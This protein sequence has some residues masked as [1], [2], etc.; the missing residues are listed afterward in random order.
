MFSEPLS[1]SSS[2][3]ISHGRAMKIDAKLRV[4]GRFS[5][6]AQSL[7]QLRLSTYQETHKGAAYVCFLSSLEQNFGNSVARGCQQVGGE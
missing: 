1:C 6:T 7:P 4:L 3:P 2:L 5:P